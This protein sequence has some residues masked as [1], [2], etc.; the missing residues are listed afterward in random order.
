MLKWLSE[1]WDRLTTGF[2]FIPSMMATGAV[3]LAFASVQLDQSTPSELAT[4]VP[5]LY[6]GGPEG[7]AGVL[8]A[9]AGSMITII[10]L[11]CSLT[12]VVLSLAS[13]QFGPR[14]LRNFIRD[15]ITQVV[16]GTFFAAFLYCLFVLRTIRR[17]DAEFVP[18][19]SVTLG[20]LF[21]VA[22]LAVLIF[23]VH[24]MAMSIQADTL[25]ARVSDELTSTINRLYPERIGDG[26]DA[27][28]PLPEGA[29]GTVG[30]DE[31]G[32]AQAVDA[33]AVMAAASEHDVVIEL[34]H[35]PGNYVLLGAP[36]ARVWP[37][38]RVSDE[39]AQAVNDAIE[40][41]PARTPHQDVEFVI[42]QLVEIALRALSPGINDP[43]TAVTCIDRL[44]SGLAKLAKRQTPSKY[45]KDADGRLRVVAHP[46]HFTNALDAAFN[47]IRQFARNSAAI[48]IRLLEVI[49]DLGTVVA[50]ADDRAALRRHTE[51][52]ARAAH[53]S[54]SEPN[55]KQDVDERVAEIAAALG[56][57]KV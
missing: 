42:N 49:A 6:G 7:A 46:V 54:L 56:G 13:S 39:L 3:A 40:R 10:G 26:A 32:Y 45:R 43:F 14:L 55:D 38:E 57:G 47:Q 50:R 1:V 12:L 21:A 53:D 16:L 25:V 22:G 29:S 28:V 15:R 52:I 24:H 48:M 18:H 30:A 37:A 17:G 23:F 34:L 33:E 27:D 36:V 8:T 11:V 31:D 20:V 44:A 2:W 19:I 9:I 51:M 5:W 35:R 4:K 41:G